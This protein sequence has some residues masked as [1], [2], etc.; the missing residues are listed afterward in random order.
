M[1]EQVDNAIR[2][3]NMPNVSIRV[4]DTD[5]AVSEAHDAIAHG[6]DVIIA[7]GIQANLIKH[8]TNY[9][10]IEIAT[11][12]QEMGLLA[13][14]A[15]SMLKKPNPVI[16]V[17]GLENMFC[18]TQHF[19][20]LFG[21]TLR[22]YYT[23]DIECIP[24]LVAEAVS[25]GADLIIGGDRANKYAET[26]H[27]PH[28]FVD[29]LGEEAINTALT[30]ASSVGW[31]IDLEKKHL[32]QLKTLLDYSFNGIIKTDSEG[33]VEAVNSIAE[34][35]LNMD[36]ENALGKPISELIGPLSSSTL[37]S[38]LAEGREYFISYMIIN[39]KAFAVS[40][41]PIMVGAKVVDGSII[42][43]N[44]VQTI[45]ELESKI[46]S[47]LYS[48]DYKSNY[49]FSLLEK[50]SP[51]LKRELELARVAAASDA[52]VLISGPSGGEKD[53]LP[54][55][56]CSES[57]KKDGPYIFVKCGAYQGEAQIKYL[58]EDGVGGNNEKRGV[59]ELARNGTLALD[60]IEHLC[61]QSQHF[62]V[63]LLKQ[64]ILLNRNTGK[65]MPIDFRLISTTEKKLSTYVNEGKFDA[66]LYYLISPIR[67]DIPP[68]FKRAEDISMWV[69]H[70]IRHYC[71]RYSRYISLTANAMN[72][73][74]KY[75]WEGNLSQLK[76]FCESAVILSPWRTV[77]EKFI[78]QLL[79]SSYPV[80]TEKP[81]PES[82]L[83]YMALEV[84]E[85]E[86]LLKKHNGNRTA[87][88]KDL[89]ISTTTLWRRVKKYN[90]NTKGL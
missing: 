52:A 16:A 40:I 68:L 42:S 21:I 1:A 24:G 62:L 28:L 59:V 82:P 55:C 79:A 78:R 36:I 13:K 26:L 41:A 75:R 50:R 56:I 19:D 86:S 81:S 23:D 85:I 88:A 54:R 37:S 77:N 22:C 31:A 44:E 76:G 20:I 18:N 63:N 71:N 25:E 49:D 34:D 45:V 30:T 29:A 67:I 6:A 38:A 72:A 35:M 32:A 9:T 3:R 7:R 27:V 12:S 69:S 58:F 17:I 61:K 74:Q 4:I 60:G 48:G 46:R 65:P 66:E 73:L 57:A 39:N 89:G 84:D 43:F 15:I 90:I 33:R 14:R 83:G 5:K 2:K 10:V 70:Y 8:H 11:T 64:K 80:F 51:T 87:V 47:A 53:F